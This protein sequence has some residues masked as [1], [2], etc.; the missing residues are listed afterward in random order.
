MKALI[1]KKGQLLLTIGDVAAPLALNSA[2]GQHF[3]GCE[4]RPVPPLSK[5]IGVVSVN[6]D[7]GALL[8]L[9]KSNGFALASNGCIKQI[10]V[11]MDDFLNALQMEMKLN[12]D[13]LEPLCVAREKE[14]EKSGFWETFLQGSEDT[15]YD[16]D[17]RILSSIRG[18]LLDL[19]NS[20]EF[21]V[22]SPQYLDPFYDGAPC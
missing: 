1:N 9:K 13:E 8:W 4:N 15:V 10:N 19:Y 21:I 22:T 7:V 14:F 18:N 11:A 5:I 17:I 3:W 20:I 16:D 2:T 12:N 6:G